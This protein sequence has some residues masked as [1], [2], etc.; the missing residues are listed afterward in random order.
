MR[1][2]K[3]EIEEKKKE[4]LA[5][6]KS[7]SMEGLVKSIEVSKVA[8]ERWTDNLFLVLKFIKSKTTIDPSELEKQFKIL[9][10]LDYLT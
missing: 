7:N 9:K 10:D 6:E 1:K 5:L 2:I 4:I 3:Q 8:C